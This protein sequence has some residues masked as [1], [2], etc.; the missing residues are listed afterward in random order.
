M[1]LFTGNK[2]PREA[3]AMERTPTFEQ[4]RRLNIYLIKRSYGLGLSF[5]ILVTIYY[6]VKV[7]FIP[8]YIS[9][10]G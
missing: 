9:L 2:M 1:R 4:G 3:V 7:G 6:L 8:P 10:S 5:A